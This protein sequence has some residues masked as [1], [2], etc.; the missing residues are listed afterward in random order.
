MII[1]RRLLPTQKVDLWVVSSR[2]TILEEISG[3]NKERI[4]WLHS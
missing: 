4:F 2:K 1:T 3:H